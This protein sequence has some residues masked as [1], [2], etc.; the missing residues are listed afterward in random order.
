MH[1]FKAGQMVR[2][3]ASQ[4]PNAPP[5]GTYEIVRAMPSEGALQYRIKGLHEQ[6]QRVVDEALLAENFEEPRSNAQNSFEGKK[7]E[8]LP[9]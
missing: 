7:R 8:R 2:V 3:L 6:F 5:P 4:S 9:V 1:K